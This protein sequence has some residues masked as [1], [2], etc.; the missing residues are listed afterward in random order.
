MGE[1]VEPG[2]QEGSKSLTLVRVSTVLVAESNLLVIG[3][4]RLS[5]PAERVRLRT[6]PEPHAKVSCHGH[7]VRYEPASDVPPACEG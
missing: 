7:T 6:E 3:L 2:S 4:W 1:V 5:R